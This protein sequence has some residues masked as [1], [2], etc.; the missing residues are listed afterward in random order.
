MTIQKKLSQIW[1]TAENMFTMN[2][3]EEKIKNYPK[4]KI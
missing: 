4:F 3:V 1:E 2:G